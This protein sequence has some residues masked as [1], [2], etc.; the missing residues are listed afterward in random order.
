M[1]SE[2][3][4]RVRQLR[5]NLGWSQAELATRVSSI[6][7]K[8]VPQQSLQQ[9]EDGTVGRPR[10]L[11]ELAT[12][13]GVSLNYLLYG[14]EGEV[15]RIT[16]GPDLLPLKEVPIVGTAE[17]GPDAQ[18]EELG[19]PVGYG[20]EYLDAPSRDNNAYSLL[21]SG[22]SMS[23]RM[24]PGEAILVEPNH[25]VQPGDE[26]VVRL[27]SGEVMVKELTYTRG[28]K[29][30]LDSVSDHERI[31]VDKKDVALMHYVAGV[32]RVGSIRQ[33]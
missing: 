8:K 13:L 5:E 30:A 6:C 7:N 16:P 24:K 22:T 18:W 3:A 14:E 20:E 17:G 4:D 11:P 29:I 26:V 10:Y 12:T 25:S 27:N 32:F 21:V 23:P 33:R 15:R 2:L 9:L 28:S 1:N 31:V 19:Y